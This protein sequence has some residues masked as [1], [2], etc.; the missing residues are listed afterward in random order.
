VIAR[1][2]SG[3]CSDGALVHLSPSPAPVT[4]SESDAYSSEPPA[5]DLQSSPPA[6]DPERLARA[7]AESFEFL[8]RLLR[9]LGVQPD[10]AV[11]DAVQ[12]VFEIAARKSDHMAVGLERAFLFKTAVLVAAEERRRQQRARERVAEQE[13]L[14]MPSSE[15]DPEA[16]LVARRNRE[17]LDEVLDSLPHKHRTVFVLYE[18]E[19]LTCAEIGML[20]GVPEGTVASRL[21]RGRERFRAAARR[22]R[23][24]LVR[25][26]P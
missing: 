5:A 19:G 26:V 18:L 9:R 20:L 12:R 17:I 23:A 14:D 8:W 21:R 15:L 4:A 16:A 2:G 13:P 7:A 1:E 22:M 10:A 3:R 11:D 6:A 25:R 24:R